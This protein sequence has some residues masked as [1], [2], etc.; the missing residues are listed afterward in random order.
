VADYG[1]SGIRGHC[2]L[3]DVATVF[4]GNH[5]NDKLGELLNLTCLIYSKSCLRYVRQTT[6]NLSAFSKD[7]V[8]SRLLAE[9]HRLLASLVAAS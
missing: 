2:R 3:S 5:F 4:N 9:W 7:D 6:G 1:S 8:V